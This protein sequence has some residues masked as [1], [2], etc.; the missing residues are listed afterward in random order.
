MIT[1]APTT[2]IY[3]PRAKAN[4]HI[5]D[6]QVYAEHGYQAQ[7]KY[8]DTRTTYKYTPGWQID[9]TKIQLWNRHGE[10]HRDYT[11]PITLLEE[12]QQIGE[13]LGLTPDNHH[14]LDGGILDK[15]HPHVKN[16][17]AIWDILVENSKSLAGTTYAQR[18][19]RLQAL[20]GDRKNFLAGNTSLHVGHSP[21]PNTIIPQNIEPKDWLTYWQEILKLNT[22]FDQPLIEG[23]VFKDPNGIL[24]TGLRQANNH[25]WLARSRVTTGRHQF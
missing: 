10:R 11:A 2:Y 20:G 3:P 6:A 18:Y 8:N 1:I 13:T 16:T 15:K 17:A 24:T 7:P 14:L 4:I 22:N 25:D 5:S 21:T 23:Y 19:E 12:L 9:P